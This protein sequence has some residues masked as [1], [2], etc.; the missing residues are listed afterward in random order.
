MA[1]GGPLI[2][3]R[4]LSRTYQKLIALV[5]GILLILCLLYWIFYPSKNKL[6]S[7]P[8]TV[9]VASA[10]KADVPVFL[11]ALGAVTPTDSVTVKTQING[12]LEKVFFK[13]GQMVRAKSLLAQ[14]DPRPYIALINQYEGQLIRDK[15]LLENARI[16][17][18]RYENLWQQDSVAKQILDT[19]RW[20]VKQYEGTVKSDEGLLQTARVN[21][22]YTR[23]VTPINGRVGLRFVDPGNFVQTSDPNGL[24]IINNIHPVDVVFTLAE[25]YVPQVMKQIKAGKKM[26][27]KAFDRT[28]KQLL[29]VGVLS[30]IDNQIDSTTGTVKLKAEFQN[31]DDSLFPNQFVNVQLMVNKLKGAILVPTPGIQH[32]VKGNYVFALDSNKKVVQIKP[33]EIGVNFEDETV[34]TS[35]IK[36]GDIIVVEGTDKL[37]DGAEV[38]VFEGS[39]A[40]GAS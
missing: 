3:Q 12:K 27:V 16:D 2:P 39:V 21:L 36:E 33:V 1:T 7:H 32:G 19:Q 8:I 35:G 11:S 37:T 38:K 29:A 4:Y 23:I 28:Q 22:D 18:Q 20:L 10:K 14:I 25:D 17:L 34:V 9:V 24:F 26:A 5:C 6:H 13:E 31:K 40:R 30:T 15:A